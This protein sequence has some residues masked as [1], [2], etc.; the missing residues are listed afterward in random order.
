MKVLKQL[1]EKWKVGA[2]QFWL[3]MVTFALGGSLSGRLCSKI[4]N[5]V[6]LEKNWAYWLVYPLFLTILWPFSEDVPSVPAA[7]SAPACAR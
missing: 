7:A 5:L 1:Q 4:L 6:F 3:I 2:L